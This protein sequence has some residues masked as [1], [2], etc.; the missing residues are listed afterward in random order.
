MKN[1]IRNYF[2]NML[3]PSFVFGS[4]TGVVTAVIICLYELCAAYVIDISKFCYETLRSAPVWFLLVFPLLFFIAWFYSRIYRRYTNLGGG[5]IPTSIGALRGILPIHGWKNL[6]GVF[7]MSLPTFLIGVPLG[8][9]G[10]SVQMG[11]A[12]G[13]GCVRSFTKKHRAWERYSMTGGACAGFAVATGAPISG[14]LFAVEEAHQRISPMLL[15]VSATSVMFAEITARLLSFLLPIHTALFPD[16]NP[17][18]LTLRDIWLPAV[19]GIAVGLFAVL[20]LKYYRAIRNLIKRTLKKISSV[21]VIFSVLVLTVF[22]GFLSGEF[23]STGRELMLSLFNENK[24]V[25]LLLLILAVRSTL[26]LFANSANITGGL[27]V[28]IL[29]LGVLVSSVISRAATALFGLGEEY[30]MIILILG[31]TACISSMMKMPL[32]AIVFA[33][34][35]LSCYINV[36]YVIIV[37]AVSYVITE[38]FGMKSIN[39]IVIESRTESLHQNEEPQVKETFVTVNTNSFAEGKQIRDIFWPNNT[40]VLSMKYSSRDHVE[41]DGHGGKAIRAGDV[42]HIRYSTYD[43]KKTLEEIFAIVGKQEVVETDVDKV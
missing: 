43:S 8:N 28:P 23:V 4:V 3:I 35:A 33:V 6:I 40:F 29:T 34:E 27:F 10:P 16:F 31:I 7:T 14:I 24:T 42:L 38:F 20:C 32:T 12:V 36:L 37:A 11:T 21:Y 22:L 41:I 2:V 18:T 30:L 25:L 5:G 1:H 19:I 15:T 13:K 17:I 26:T 9:E 39:D